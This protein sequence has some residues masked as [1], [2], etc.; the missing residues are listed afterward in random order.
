[1]IVSYYSFRRNYEILFE[2]KGL[3][4]FRNPVQFQKGMSD[5]D[6]DRRYRSEEQCRAALFTWRWP[7]GFMLVRLAFVALRTPPMPYRLLKLAVNCA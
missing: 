2:T 4:M 6:F 1:M 5:A 7:K 3:V